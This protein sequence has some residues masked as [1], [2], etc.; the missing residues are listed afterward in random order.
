MIWLLVILILAGAAPM[1]AVDVPRQ[2]AP[3]EP[4]GCSRAKTALAR[5]TLKD[6]KLLL[7][8]APADLHA[9]IVA[10]TGPAPHASNESSFMP[11]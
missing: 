1:T 11:S 4:L 7:A 2:A 6:A 8:P 5:A 3:A 10:M 9:R